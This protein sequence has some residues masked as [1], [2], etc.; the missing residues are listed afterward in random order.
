MKIRIDPY[1]MWQVD[2]REARF[3]TG[4]T[5]AVGGGRANFLPAGLEKHLV[6]GLDQCLIR[7]PVPVE[8]GFLLDPEW[9]RFAGVMKR[10][11]PIVLLDY[12]GSR[13]DATAEAVLAVR[14]FARTDKR[15]RRWGDAVYALGLDAREQPKV[16]WVRAS[17][18]NL[19]EEV[20]MPEPLQQLSLVGG[21]A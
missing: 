4:L 2:G 15:E 1:D 14:I 16:E 18:R 3:I 17:I 13:I 5:R 21:E 20:E 9:T 10:K 6:P 12:R 8:G 19:P 11:G 7:H